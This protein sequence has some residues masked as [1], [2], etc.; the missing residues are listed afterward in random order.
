MRTHDANYGKDVLMKKVKHLVL[1][2][3]RAP[4]IETV[5]TVVTVHS[6]TVPAGGLLIE[7]GVF[8]YK[9]GKKTFS[10]DAVTYD[11]LTHDEAKKFV[12]RYKN[13]LKAHRKNTDVFSFFCSSTAHPFSKL[14]SERYSPQELDLIHKE[15]YREYDKNVHEV[16]LTFRLRRRVNEFDISEMIGNV[17]YR[18]FMD[19]VTKHNSIPELF[20]ICNIGTDPVGRM[21]SLIARSDERTWQVRPRAKFKR[22]L[23]DLLP[24]HPVLTVES[25]VS[26]ETERTMYKVGDKSFLYQYQA[27][28][29]QYEIDKKEHDKSVFV[30]RSFGLQ[31]A[32][33]IGKYPALQWLMEN[34]DE[35]DLVGVLKAFTERASEGIITPEIRSQLSRKEADDLAKELVQ[36]RFVE[37][38]ATELHDE[39]K[40]S[41]LP[42]E[43]ASHFIDVSLIQE[44]VRDIVEDY[45]TYMPKNKRAIGYMRFIFERDNGDRYYESR[46]VMERYRVFRKQPVFVHPEYR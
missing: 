31:Q 43:M 2:G 14:L 12:T 7:E 45:S 5:P 6:V 4:K 24:K 16:T 34:Y 36:W 42:L 33:Q 44:E 41:D 17:V 40:Y 25:I 9:E 18:D 46:N 23:D 11:F 37:A 39:Q 26:T 28:E 32:G 27:K 38:I 29:R 30:A 20:D 13:L 35:S 21:Y 22:I 3:E 19:Y 10:E 1:F 15:I 8:P